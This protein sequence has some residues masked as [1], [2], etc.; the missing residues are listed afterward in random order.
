MTS[1]SEVEDFEPLVGKTFHF[2]ETGHALVLTRLEVVPVSRPGQRRPFTLV[3][4]GDPGPGYM[5]EGLR[6]CHVEEGEPFALYVS[7]IG[8]P[9]RTRQ[10]YQAVFN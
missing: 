5:R 1:P 8:T 2:P 7:P 6:H 3:F 10:D 4:S 9:V